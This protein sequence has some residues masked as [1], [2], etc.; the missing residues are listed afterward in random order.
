MN[1]VAIPDLYPG[2][3]KIN[4]AEFVAALITWET[5]A[6]HCKGCIT[7]LEVDNITAKA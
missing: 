4:I 2:N 5:Y 6:R 7:T 1:L 3:V